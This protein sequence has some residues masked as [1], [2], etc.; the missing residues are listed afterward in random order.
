MALTAN[1]ISIRRQLFSDRRFMKNFY[2][3]QEQKPA[4]RHAKNS[5]AAAG[6]FFCI[7][8]AE[9]RNG[10]SDYFFGVMAVTVTT[11]DSALLVTRP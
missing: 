4:G 6:E 8:D 10:K 1:F 3:A 11:L 9:R 2:N 5:P 7:K